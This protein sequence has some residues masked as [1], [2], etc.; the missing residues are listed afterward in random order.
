MVCNTKYVHVQY[1]RILRTCI[2]VSF[3]KRA[4]VWSSNNVYLF[5][6]RYITFSMFILRALI[7]KYNLILK[8]APWRQLLKW[9]NIQIGNLITIVNSHK[10]WKYDPNII[11]VSRSHPFTKRYL[12]F[13]SFESNGGRNLMASFY[14][15]HVPHS[16]ILFCFSNTLLYLAN[17]FDILRLLTTAT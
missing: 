1:V 13:Y 3:Y 17:T 4:L 10:P 5:P 14:E 2:F 16:L 9:E 8:I 15:I 12:S 7:W 6:S 11:N